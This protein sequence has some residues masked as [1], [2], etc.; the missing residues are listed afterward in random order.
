MIWDIDGTL[1]HCFGAGSD[2]ISATYKELYN[3]DNAM[4]NVSL[5]GVV[6]NQVMSI[7]NQ[8]YRIQKF[9]KSTFFTRYGHHLKLTMTAT[10]LPKLVD[11]I[12]EVLDDLQKPGLYH[13]IGTGN[14]FIGATVKLKLTGLDRFFEYGAYGDEVDDRNDLV[15]LAKER[16]EAYYRTKFSEKDVMVIGD[17]PGDIISARENQF[18]SVAT[19]TGYSQELLLMRHHPDYIISNLKELKGVMDNQWPKAFNL[20]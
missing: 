2:A 4:N 20:F 14:C 7:I 10:K 6:D 17:T 15:R 13:I 5:S 16:A 3:V 9:D 19:M 8:K 18:I 11:D 1:M 12:V